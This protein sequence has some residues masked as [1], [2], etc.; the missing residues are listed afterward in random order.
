MTGLRDLVIIGGGAA[1]IEAAEQLP[2]GR[3]DKLFLELH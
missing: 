2:L 3:A 1:G